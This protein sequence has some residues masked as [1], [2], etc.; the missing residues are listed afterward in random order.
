M[1]QF[2]WQKLE[3]SIS[4]LISRPYHSL[5]VYIRLDNKTSLLNEVDEWN[6]WTKFDLVDFQFEIKTFRG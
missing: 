1:T 4:Q 5:E 3:I 6:C 2:P